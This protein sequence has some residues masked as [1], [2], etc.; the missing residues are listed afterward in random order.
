MQK[1]YL[2]YDLLP[3]LE[4]YKF[5][6][7]LEGIFNQQPLKIWDQCCGGGRHVIITAKIGH[8]AYG[9]DVSENGILH[10]SDW[11]KNENL[12][13]ELKISDMTNNPWQGEKFHGVICWDAL[14]HNVIG[15]I[16]KAVEIIYE[17]TIENGMF[18]ANLI[19]TKSDGFG[20]GDEIEKNTFIPNEG[21]DGCLMHHYFDEQEIRDV[22]KKW[23]IIILAEKV[24]NY[25]ETEPEFYKTN[26]FPYTKWQLLV[27]KR[28]A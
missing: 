15:N 28:S 9:S 24:V 8:Q 6:K 17:N 27:Q 19:S 4:V 22:F 20:K 1:N 10:L 2:T 3:Q 5:I 18:I 16:K 12:N 7:K 13:A 26:P 23:N 25:I 21:F 14:H 11:L